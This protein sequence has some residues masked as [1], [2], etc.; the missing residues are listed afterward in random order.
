MLAFQIWKQYRELSLPQALR[1]LT[2][3]V[4]GSLNLRSQAAL[5]PQNEP[6]AYVLNSSLSF[7][8]FGNEVSGSSLRKKAD[9][10]MIYQRFHPWNC[11]IY[12]PSASHQLLK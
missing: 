8:K 2:N 6:L 11:Q 5:E 9:H 3:V 1:D 4:P 12:R 7:C 10:S